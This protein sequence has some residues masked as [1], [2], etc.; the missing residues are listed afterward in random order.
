MAYHTVLDMGDKAQ[1][2]RPKEFHKV[3]ILIE[4]I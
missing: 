3:Y 1:S 4:T 2:K